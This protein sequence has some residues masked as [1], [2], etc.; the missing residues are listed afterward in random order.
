[1]D[2]TCLYV[3]SL[4]SSSFG[5]ENQPSNDQGLCKEFVDLGQRY[6]LQLF[7]TKGAALQVQENQVFYFFCRTTYLLLKRYS[8]ARFPYALNAQHFEVLLIL[9]CRSLLFDIGGMAQTR[10]RISFPIGMLSHL[11]YSVT[12]LKLV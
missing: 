11:F 5:T 6:V 3:A 2:Q 7:E 12:S 1:T 10:I 9:N 8:F 4:K